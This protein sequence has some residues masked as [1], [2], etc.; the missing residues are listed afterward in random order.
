MA[1]ASESM[2]PAASWRPTAKRRR[3]APA[4]CGR[5]THTYPDEQP[6]LPQVDT[7][8]GHEPGSA[9][10]PGFRARGLPVRPGRDGT[11]RARAQPGAGILAGGMAGR[12]LSEQRVA[13]LLRCRLLSGPGSARCAWLARPADGA[14][15]GRLLAARRPACL[16][17]RSFGVQ[18][19]LRLAAGVPARP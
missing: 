17:A 19:S 5:A 6:C 10:R 8:A 14:S 11:G 2:P 15:K 18:N 7:C 16:R 4:Q 3:A 12:Q 9:A 13:S 1:T